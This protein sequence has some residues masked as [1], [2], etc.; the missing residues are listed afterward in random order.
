MTEMLWAAGGLVGLL[1]LI[2]LGSKLAAYG[3]LQ[4]RENFRR[5]HNK[6]GGSNGKA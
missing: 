1:A 2:Y 4:G 6:K 5:D 3:W